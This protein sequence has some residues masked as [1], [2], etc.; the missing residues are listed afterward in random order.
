MGLIAKSPVVTNLR[1][2]NSKININHKTTVLM[3]KN[4]EI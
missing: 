3:K 4:E 2:T 1:N